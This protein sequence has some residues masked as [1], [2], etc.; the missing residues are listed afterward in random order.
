MSFFRHEEIYRPMSSMPGRPSSNRPR[1]HRCD[2]FPAG[3]SSVGCTPA[4][5]ASASPASGHLEGK[6]IRNTMA[7]QGTARSVLTGCLS[8]GD[9]PICWQ[10][11]QVFIWASAILLRDQFSQ[12]FGKA[13][14]ERQDVPRHRSCGCSQLSHKRQACNQNHSKYRDTASQRNESIICSCMCWAN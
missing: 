13:W 3:Y 11:G 4:E 8:P 7:F 9:N 10:M 2:E 12:D 1:P 6:R 14:T 5:P